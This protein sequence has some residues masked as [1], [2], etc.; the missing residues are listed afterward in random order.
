[1]Y[2]QERDSPAPLNIP[3]PTPVENPMSYRKSK[4][5]MDVG[6]GGHLTANFTLRIAQKLCR[7]TLLHLGLVTCRFHFGRTRE[8]ENPSCA[9]FSDLVDVSMTPRTNYL[10][11]R[12]HQ[13]RKL[14]SRKL[15]NRF[16][17]YVWGISKSRTSKVLILWKRRVQNKKCRSV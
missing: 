3:T 16:H 4:K 1:M 7:I 10:Y 13:I 9:W 11:L 8:T 2:F 6:S 17:F 14:N 5:N 12:T 15:P